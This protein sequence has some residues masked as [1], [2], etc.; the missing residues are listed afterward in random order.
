MKKF[1]TIA[2]AAALAIFAAPAMAQMSWSAM[3]V[4]VDGA[5]NSGSANIDVNFTVLPFGYVNLAQTSVNV[6][7]GSQST[8][9]SATPAHN[10]NFVADANHGFELVV[11]CGYGGFN[12]GYATRIARARQGAANSNSADFGYVANINGHAPQGQFGWIDNQTSPITRNAH[13]TLTG[14]ISV[15]AKPT[16]VHSSNPNTI[17][18]TGSYTGQLVVTLTLDP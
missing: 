13:E 1:T 9:G 10:V 17:A 16:D 6:D 2:L 12:A 5:G 15:M 3:N 11:S 7:V 18:A 8:S 14:A 4:Q